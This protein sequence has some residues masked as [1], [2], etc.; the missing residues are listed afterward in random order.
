MVSALSLSTYLFLIGTKVV[1]KHSILP[2]D[3]L[4]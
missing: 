3:W 2:P 1:Q 4:G